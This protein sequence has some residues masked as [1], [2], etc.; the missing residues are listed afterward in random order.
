LFNFTAFGL[1]FASAFESRFYSPA[2]GNPQVYCSLGHVPESLPGACSAGVCCEA[3]PTRFLLSLDKIARYL[4]SDGEQI[5][6]EPAPGANELAVRLFLEGP[7]F[8]A[9]LY[10]RGIL[11]LHA[12]AIATDRGAVVFAGASGSGKS[13]LAAEFRRRG[14]RVLADEICAI[15]PSMPPVL[16]PAGP[17]LMLWADALDHLKLSQAELEP[18]RPELEKYILPQGGVASSSPQPLRAVYELEVTSAAEPALKPVSGLRKV[19]FLAR[20]VYRPN[21]AVAMQRAPASL[22]RIAAIAPHV[23]GGIVTRPVT[24]FSIAEVADLIAGDLAA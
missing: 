2:A 9:L 6:V 12:S 10:Q 13:T 24:G 18:A 21:F 4:V 11:P 20:S 15:P 23:R 5:T 1:T 3:T 19:E 14:Y 22:A 16:L 8:G 17:S 7:V